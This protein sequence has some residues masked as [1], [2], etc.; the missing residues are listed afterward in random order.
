M[1]MMMSNPPD[2]RRGGR[3]QPM[4][5]VEADLDHYPANTPSLV[6]SLH[7]I[8]YYQGIL[9]NAKNYAAVS[10]LDVSEVVNGKLIERELIDESQCRVFLD[11]SDRDRASKGRH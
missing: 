9:S 2:L 3:L 1:A 6:G 4:V 7:N 10:Q 8:G 5:V 11:V